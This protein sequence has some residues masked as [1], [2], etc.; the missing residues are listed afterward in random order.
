MQKRCVARKELNS[1][2]ASRECVELQ[3][4]IS[5][6]R[7]KNGLH[8]EGICSILSIYAVS[9]VTGSPLDEVCNNYPKFLELIL[10]SKELQDRM[11][12]ELSRRTTT[13][14]MS[15]RLAETE[16]AIS[17]LLPDIIPHCEKLR[18]L[19][20]GVGGYDGE[21]G[22]VGIT[23]VEL[24]MHL[25]EEFGGGHRIFGGDILQ[26]EFTEQQIGGSSLVLF[27][28]DILKP[29]EYIAHVA[30]LYFVWQFDI[31]RCSN[32]LVNFDKEMQAIAIGNLRALAAPHSL[33]IYNLGFDDEHIAEIK[34]GEF[35]D[36]CLIMKDRHLV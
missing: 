11:V 9:K 33:L 21:S 14:T 15:R 8:H 25:N 28:F 2:I 1:V 19:D 4:R 6:E 16:R 36:T 31:I 13:R 35:S 20:A 12:G 27:P 5:L 24:L 23:T 17:L 29:T 30:N 18:V 3:R 34:K 22:L 32:L 10:S 26:K 7:A